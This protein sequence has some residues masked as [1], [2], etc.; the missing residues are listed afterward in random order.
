MSSVNKDSPVVEGI[1]TY[2][3]VKATI[4][5]SVSCVVAICLMGIGV[6]SY[7]SNKKNPDQNKSITGTVTQINFCD[8]NGCNVIIEYEDGGIKKTLTTTTRG[9]IQPG[10]VITVSQGISNLGAICIGICGCLIL[11]CGISYLTFV[12]TNKYAAIDSAMSSQRSYSYGPQ[13]GPYYGPRYGPR[14]GYNPGI[15]IRI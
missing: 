11:F 7:L 5:F 1:A 13:Y 12:M 9:N 8:R 15:N 6:M 4:A 2:G 3:R 14:Y 10:D